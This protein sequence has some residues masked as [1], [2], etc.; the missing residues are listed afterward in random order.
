[1]A[2]GPGRF[3][4]LTAIA[5]LMAFVVLVALGTWQVQRLHWK[6]GLLATIR[7]RMA[8]PPVELVP[9]LKAD[10]GLA[11][12]EYRPVRVE[13]TF[14]HRFERHFLATY[15]GEPGF[16]VYTPLKLDDGGWLFVNRGFVPDGRQD[17]AT[18][19][20]GQVSGRV[21][22]TGL[23]RV[24]L[25]GKPSSF[26]P[27]NETDKN[28]FFWKDLHAMAASSGLPAGAHVLPLFVDADKT[29]N[30]GGLPVGGVTIVDLPNN[31]LQYAITWY[32]LAAA[33]VGVVFVWLRRRSQPAV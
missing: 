30:P 21:A 33:L 6:E 31:H 27:D 17:P 10:P 24:E 16:Y 32:G 1:M 14:E 20:Q 12:Q 7:E 5:G 2:P 18:R 26:V 13:G 3:P 9:A 15:D 11:K 8:M 29:P 25:T 28:I 22:V 4:W 23:L 19:P